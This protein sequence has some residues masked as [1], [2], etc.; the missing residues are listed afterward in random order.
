MPDHK[1]LRDAILALQAA[2]NA[3]DSAFARLEKATDHTEAM[4]IWKEGHR[5]VLVLKDAHNAAY[6]HIHELKP[7]SPKA[8][9]LKPGGKI[10]NPPAKKARAAEKDAEPT[11]DRNDDDK[12]SP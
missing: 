11:D 10:D 1:T 2:R 12:D 8:D 5:A 3:Y 7:K 6:K 4:D 9:K